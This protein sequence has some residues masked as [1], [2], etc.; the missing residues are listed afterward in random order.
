[1]CFRNFVFF[2]CISNYDLVHEGL[3]GFVIALLPLD[4]L[5]T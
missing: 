2:R 3:G 5:N 4:R 1:M